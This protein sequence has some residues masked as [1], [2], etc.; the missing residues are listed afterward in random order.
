MRGHMGGTLDIW[1]ERFLEA[2]LC[3]PS[4]EQDPGYLLGRPVILPRPLSMLQANSPAVNA[5]AVVKPWLQ[6]HPARHLLGQFKE[7]RSF[8]KLATPS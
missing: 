7:S 3:F 5:L 4:A 8:F 6:R 2:A 1:S